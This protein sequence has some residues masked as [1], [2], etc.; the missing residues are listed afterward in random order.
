MPEPETGIKPDQPQASQPGD[1]DQ[2]QK[3]TKPDQSVMPTDQNQPTI[4]DDKTIEKDGQK[5]VPFD[6]Y[7]AEKDKRQELE[8]Q[9]NQLKGQQ[10]QAAQTP[11]GEPQ[12]KPEEELPD[13][14]W[15]ELL[16]ISEQPS[17]TPAQQTTPAQ[18]TQPPSVPT[19]DWFR[20]TNERIAEMRADGNEIGAYALLRQLEKGYESNMKRTA[21]RWIKDYDNLPLSTISDEEVAAFAQNPEA[22]R[23]ILA[24]AKSGNFGGKPAST[25]SANGNNAQPADWQELIEKSRQ[26]GREEAMRGL[27]SSSG[28]SGEGAR[29]STVAP[30]ETYELDESD[31]EVVRYMNQ[32]GIPRE[33]WPQYAEALHKKLEGR[34]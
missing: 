23:G 33:K 4:E 25:P 27:A 22:L 19:Q 16:G 10:P 18:P 11:T 29:G 21:R 26:E 6:S 20:Q 8:D 34:F 3:G 1:A 12:P 5:V 31:P 7:K 9:L 15:D 32:R 17:Q 14:N 24:K 2:E 30:G 28:T 13:I